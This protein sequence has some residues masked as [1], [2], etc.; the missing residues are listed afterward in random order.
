[1]TPAALALVLLALADEGGRVAVFPPDGPG[2]GAAGWIGAAVAETLP[3]AL[4]RAGVP[5]VPAADRWRAQ[6]SLG[7]ASP[8]LTRASAIRVA[9]ALG[10]SRVVVGTWDQAGAD[11]ALSLRVVDTGRAALGPPLGATSPLAGFGRTVHALAWDLAAAGSP[12]PAG[13]RESLARAAERVPFDA[14]RALGEGLAAGDDAARVAGLRR[15]LDL[16]PAYEE[17][18]L[19]LARLLVDGGRFAEAREA[20]SRVAP[21]SPFA[22]DARFLDG[23]ALLGLGRAREADVLYADLAA[24][25]ATAAA[26]GNRAAARLR[27]GPGSGASLL[28]RQA[29]EAEPA[30]VDL[31]FSLGWALLVEGDPGAAAFWL[32]GAVRR[33]PADAE[34]RLALSWALSAAGRSEEAEEQ[35]RAATALVPALEPMRKPDLKR[36]LERVLPSEQGLLLDPA[37]A[38][39]A[40]ASRAGVGRAESLLATGDVEGA[41]GELSRAVLLDPFAPRPHLL[42]GRARLARGEDEAAIAALRTAL[43]CR[44]DPAVRRELAALLHAKGRAAEARAILGE[45]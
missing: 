23:V 2:G 16:H 18:A 40:E 36:R 37:R 41:L 11:L 38:K 15:A 22:R 35:W 1:V 24:R 30:S 8:G 26:L 19:A 42:A 9:E 10:A 27:E 17:A 4:Q 44:D 33:D 3:R 29:V 7:V 34:G 25:R 31:P 43:W 39:D 21:A 13:D 20:V 32:R 28:L 14:L 45:P 6:Q 5:A 12:P